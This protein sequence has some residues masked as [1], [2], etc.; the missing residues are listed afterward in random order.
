MSTFSPESTASFFK[1]LYFSWAFPMLRE[2]RRTPLSVSAL[3]PLT[4]TEHPD[5][6]DPAFAKAVLRCSSSPR[7]VLSAVLSL[8]KKNLWLAFWISMLHLGALVGNP[9]LLRQLIQWLE[10]SGTH[11]QSEGYVLAAALVLVSIAGSLAIH[12][13]FQV[14]LR[15]MIRV[16]V[17]MVALIY[18]KS[19][20]LT[21]EAR[22]ATSSGQIINLMGTDAQKFV[23]AINLIFSLWFHPMQLVL[24]LVALY[25]ILG[26]PSLAG[27]AVLTVTFFISLYISRKQIRARERL[28]KHSDSRV[29]LMNEVLMSIRMIKFYSWEKS[30]EKEVQGIRSHELRELSLLAHFQSIG[31]LIFLSTPVVVAFATF[32]T[33]VAA[34]HALNVA[35][36]FS[37][38]AFFTLLRHAMLMLPDVAAAAIEANVALRRVEDFLR[39]PEIE[40]RKVA[41]GQA[42][43]VVV[44]DATWEWRSGLDAVRNIDLKVQP[45]QLVC[46]VGEVGTGKSALLQGLLGEIPLRSGICEVSGSVAFVPQ[47]AWI[48][49]DTVRNNILFGQAYDSQRYERII[50]ACGLLEDFAEMPAGDQTEIG[51]RGINISGG[52]KQR[53]SLARAAYSGTDIYLLDDPLSALDTK[54]GAQVYENLLVGELSGKTRLLV[55]HRL[56]YLEKAD[57][58]LV[59]VDGKIVE[60]GTFRDLRH[61]GG[62]FAKLWKTHLIGVSSGENLPALGDADQAAL[63]RSE[64]DL[65]HDLNDDASAAEA[66]VGLGRQLVVTEE[67]FSGVVSPEVYKHYLTLFA[68]AGVMSLLLFVFLFKEGLNVGS[69]GWLAWWSTAAQFDPLWFV[70]GFAVLG[71][72]ACASIYVRSLIISLQGLKAGKEIHNRLLKSVLRAPMS[73]FEENPVG[74]I[75]NRF[76][77][78]LEAID[79]TIPRT[80]HEVAGCAFVIISTLI[81]ILFVSPLA[82]LGIIPVVC[83][84]FVAQGYYR[85]AAREGQRLDS[86]TRSPIFAQFSESLVGAAVIRAF[87]AGPRFEKLLL[88]NLETNSRTFYTIVAANRWLGTRIETL[89]ACVVGSAA[90]AAVA[91]HQS[92]HLGFT[93]L[94]VTYA[95]A[96]TGAMNWAIRMFSQLESNMSSVERVGYYSNLAAERWEGTEAQAD[97]PAQGAICFENLELKY[98]PELPGVISN[99]NASIAPGEKI[100]VVGRTGSGKSSLLLGLYRILEANS[101][102]ILIDGVDIST[103]PLSRLREALAIIPQDPVLFR[104]TIRKNLDPFGLHDEARL[105]DVIARAHLKP[106]IDSLPLG[107]DAPVSEGGTNLSV[108]QRQLLCLA[109][110]L[111]R[112]NRILLLDEATASVDVATDALVQFTIREA[113]ADCTVI[114][115]AHRLSTI[116]DSDRIMVLEHGRL[117]EFDSP[118]RLARQEFGALRKL[119]REVGEAAA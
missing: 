109:R 15:M 25:W 56:E 32:T 33:M 116:L 31:T 87:R 108:G 107:I 65:P 113:F 98:R 115:I 22:Q 60:S 1:R 95:L 16:R 85:P 4:R 47:Q 24:S 64:S 74:R 45:G 9:L 110:A 35:D 83:C 52:Q 29:A 19:L 7:P 63:V 13:M 99:L 80:V 51:E 84:Y 49:N 92:T 39:L 59:M 94:A 14:V 3:L 102:K 2:G 18:R 11:S 62:P 69:D 21:Q 89:G 17:P 50:D 34:G 119:L 40:P 96:I 112:R 27:L 105:K 44:N 46:V 79:L 81:V 53:I 57:S 41:E 37:A 26:P 117:V 103:L 43:T 54:V 101:G 6:T 5:S 104:G 38:L 88:R 23:N 42:G 97:W 100:G 30:F 71:L 76:S 91:S 20:R 111:L 10:S 93:G 77:R 106:L 72:G 68:S 90:F 82:I 58:V 75:L 70:S 78:D 8:E 86:I 114:T 61:G 73:F 118:S 36:V 67:R 48:Q 28:M 12:H 55:T 66:S